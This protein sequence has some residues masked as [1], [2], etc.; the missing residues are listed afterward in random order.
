MQIAKHSVVTIDYTLR[1][2]DGTVIDTS[3]GGE[4]LVY[5]HGAMNI[6]PGLENALEGK[7][8]GESLSVAVEPAEGY[9]ERNDEMV[10]S[11]PKEM[12]EGVDEIHVGA[13]YHAA[14][15]EGHPIMITVL[16]VNEDNI[17]IDGNH[18]LA[19][20]TLNFDVQIVDIR[21]ATEE[22]LAHGHAHGPGGHHHH[23]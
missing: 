23:D 3:S 14:S 5:L 4:P 2:N 6:I 10:Q 7:S 8:K 12:F 19:G 17:V 15:P 21:V 20:V 13:Q 18:P 1:D 16:E 9:G 11:V 22:E